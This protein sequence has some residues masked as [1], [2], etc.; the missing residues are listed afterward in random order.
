LGDGLR[1]A[2]EG[3]P[4]VTN[5]RHLGLMAGLSLVKDAATGEAFDPAATTALRVQRHMREEGGV[6]TRVVGDHVVFA[7]P[8][9]V[10]ASEI[11]QIVDATRAAVRSVTGV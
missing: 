3:H 4:H 2:L 9:V 10:N 7:P 6:I 5:L 1:G 8:L 11:G